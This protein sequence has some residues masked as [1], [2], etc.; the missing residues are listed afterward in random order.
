MFRTGQ[1]I[2]RMAFFIIRTRFVDIRSKTGEE[3]QEFTCCGREK[4]GRLKG[5][6]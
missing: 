6:K 3:F 5:S 2:K 4:S 1:I